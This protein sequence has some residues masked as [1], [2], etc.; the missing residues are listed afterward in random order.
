MIIWDNYSS[1]TIDYQKII[2]FW[3]NTPN[4]PTK[5]RTKNCVKV[6][7]GSRGTYKK[8]NKIRFKTSMFSL[9]LC[10]YSDAYILVKGT[11]TVKDTAV[12]GQ[13]NNDTNKKIILRDCAYLLNAQVELPIHKRWC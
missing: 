8:D 11:I 7:D 12:Q 1:I 10:D 3:D 4:Q 6:N 13:P 5:F 9:S 2:D